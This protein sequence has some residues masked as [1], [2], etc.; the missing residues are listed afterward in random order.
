MSFGIV[1]CILHLDPAYGISRSSLLNQELFTLRNFQESLPSCGISL[2]IN[3]KFC[4]LNSCSYKLKLLHID[5]SKTY[6]RRRDVW[7]TISWLLG[8]LMINSAYIIQFFKIKN[9]HIYVLAVGYIIGRTR[10]YLLLHRQ[11]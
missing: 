2:L 1:F 3:L 8:C 9:W 11:Q 5:P 7:L 6:S 4:I 10:L